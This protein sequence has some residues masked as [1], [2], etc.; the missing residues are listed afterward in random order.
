MHGRVE[1]QEIINHF[2]SLL[3]E[4]EKDEAIHQWTALKMRL[5]HQ[6]MMK[7]LDA[8]S[9]LLQAKPAELA[10]ILVLVKMMMTIS[11]STAQCER[12]FSA[13]NQ[14][15]TNKQT[16]MSPELLST[17]M[18]VACSSDN[19]ETFDPEPAARFW[20]SAG[21][22]KRKVMWKGQP[23]VVAKKQ[24]VAEAVAVPQTADEPLLPAPPDSGDESDE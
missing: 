6:R 17:R 19:L 9:A 3:K 11:A 14:L 23:S 10:S 22:R 15:K 18:R 20:L 1:I 4:E 8:Y 13:M 2:G 16:T 24:R 7:P 21:K 5:N 12:S